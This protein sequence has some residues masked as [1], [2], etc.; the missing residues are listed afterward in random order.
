MLFVL[1]AGVSAT[2]DNITAS[3]QDTYNDIENDDSSLNEIENKE[4]LKT[5]YENTTL[6]TS[7]GGDTFDDIQR[8]IS[9]ASSGDMIELDG[10]YKGSGTAIIIDKDN[11]TII[12][13][14]ATLDAQGQSRIFNITGNGVILK[15]MKFTNA[16][17][18]D[19]GGAIYWYGANGTVGNSDFSSNIATQLGG[20]I[21]WYGAN[22]TVENSNFI[23]NTAIKKGG[24]AILWDGNSANGTVNNCNF[25]NNTAAQKGGAICWCGA[26]GTINDSNFINDA[27]GDQG[28]AIFW[29]PNALDG[30]VNNSNFINNTGSNGGAFY[31]FGAHGRIDNCNFTNNRGTDGGAINWQKTY[32]VVSNCNFINN[33]AQSNGGAIY[34]EGSN[35]TENNCSFTNNM[36]ANGSA[37]YWYAYNGT[38]TNSI[39]TNNIAQSNGGAINWQGP[40]GTVTACNFANNSAA[41][42]GAIYNGGITIVDY[43]KFTNNN[44]TEGVAIETATNMTISNS[45]FIANGEY[46]IDV[47]SGAKLTLNNVS[48]DAPLVNDT[49]SMEILEA[50]D[51]VYGDDVNIK[52]L[53]NSSVISSLSSGKL[54]VKVNDV[55]YD[56]DVK[57]GIATLV[58]PEL[59][60]GTYNVNVTYIDNNISR[61]EIPVNFTVTKKGI[62]INAK[63]AAYVISYGGTYKVSFINVT[64]GT[65]VIYTLNGKKIGT[66]TIKN[67]SASIKLTAKILKTAK[68]GKK[69]MVIKIGSSNYDP[70]NKTVKITINK[71]QTKITAKAKT[72]KRTV[73][74]KKYTM[75]LKNSKNK[76]MKKA[77]VYLKVKGK[78]YAAKT[79]SKGKATFKITKLTKIGKYTATI[80]FKGSSCYKLVSK[81]VKITVKK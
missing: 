19:K 67:G 22:G 30:A 15:N 3:S 79:N 77:K 35:G 46:C 66:S 27:S 17:V 41:C 25:T 6:K 75:T 13:N 37:V 63:N 53:V 31:W 29:D 1:I 36:A 10:I 49:I 5:N 76:A 43:S 48:G 58:I 12:G 7:V 8:V 32:G 54:V 26:N 16:N 44:A 55:E 65:K 50:R 60:A 24:G 39:F 11:L 14:G 71:E 38:I 33:T 78:T 72:F 40:N 69:K 64:A 57:D 56:A 73:K 45:K 20:A 2:N 21:Y 9:S 23:N 18:A 70:T 74:T 51:V 62:A 4:I 81:S 68:A 61:A 80:K 42:G 34:W 59:D 52:V 28:G 47:E